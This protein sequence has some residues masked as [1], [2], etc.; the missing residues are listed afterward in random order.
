MKK[1]GLIVLVMIISY[2]LIAFSA[3]EIELKN[4]ETILTNS[5]WE[6]G[7]F[8]KYYDVGGLVSIPKAFVRDIRESD[9]EYIEAVETSDTPSQN[10]E[11]TASPSS[12]AVNQSEENTDAAAQEAAPPVNLTVYQNKRDEILNKYDDAK[13]RLR[14]AIQNKDSVAQNKIIEEITAIERERTQIAQE[15]KDKNNGVLPEWWQR[16]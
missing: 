15:I 10:E 1:I 8:V 13:Q 5:Y 7:S 3:Y 4:K 11:A 9:I 2:P 16:N 14:Q 12:E 6:E